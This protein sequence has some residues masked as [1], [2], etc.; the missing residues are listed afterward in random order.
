M[1]QK[2]FIVLVPIGA[3]RVQLSSFDC[4]FCFSSGLNE[5]IISAR[6]PASDAKSAFSKTRVSLIILKI[7]EIFKFLAF[8]LV[9]CH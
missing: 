7:V 4:K 3:L 1:H 8:N 2:S 5:C 9:L 6:V